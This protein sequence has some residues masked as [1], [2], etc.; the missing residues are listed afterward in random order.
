MNEIS[1]FHASQAVAELNDLIRDI[2][3][4][5]AAGGV[6]GGGN[7]SNSGTPTA[8]QV[9]LWTDATHIEG[10][11]ALPVSA[12]NSGTGASASTFW[13]GDATW[14]TPPVPQLHPGYVADRWYTTSAVALAGAAVVANLCRAFPIRIFSAVTIDSLGLN[15]TTANAGA[16]TQLAIYTNVNGR[17]GV[18]L[19]N[20]GNISTTST[21]F[22]SAALL[23]NQTLQPGIYWLLSNFDSAVTVAMSISSA[24]SFS[25]SM[26]GATSGANV[27]ATSVATTGLS[28]PL[29]FGT[30]SD[31]SGA[32]WTDIMTARTPLIAFHVIP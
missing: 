15:I 13:R 19:S 4:A 27:I 12:L 18:A 21:G 32:T 31:L 10:S 3:V 2:N 28:S 14:A 11:S 9:A 8:A 16:N 7:V 5:I 30:W 20:T 25:T 29:T 6:G 17:P 22:Q 23:A 1:S 24:T 26:T